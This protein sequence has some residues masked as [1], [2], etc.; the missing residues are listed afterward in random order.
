MILSDCLRFGDGLSSFELSNISNRNIECGDGFENFTD[1]VINLDRSI[2]VYALTVQVGFAEADAEQMSLWIDYDD[3]TIFEEE[4]LIISN[5]VIAEERIDQ[6]F[7]FTLD[8]NAP[9]GTHLLRIRAGDTNTNTG[10]DLND[11]C[12]SMQ[13]G[14][15]HDYTV[16]IGENTNPSSDL[17]VISQ[18][19]N[20]FLITMDDPNANNTLGINIY[21]ITG[22]TILSDVVEKDSNSRFSYILDMS[23]VST[24]V[25]FVRLGSNKTRK[26]AKL[27]VN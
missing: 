14:T 2:G 12:G 19:N 7:L 15:T 10:A 8:K 21:T 5:Q 4:E 22:Q 25:Y 11:P 16:E 13:F 9:L 18:P 23:Y 3:D 24:G 20:Q 26:S 17:M 1:L 6:T 27:L